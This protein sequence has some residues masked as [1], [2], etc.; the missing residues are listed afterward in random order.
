[1]SWL[2]K[3]ACLDHG[4]PLLL[5][6]LLEGDVRNPGY[7][8]NVWARSVSRRVGIAR[9]LFTFFLLF[10][11]ASQAYLTQ[12]HIHEVTQRAMTVALS[13]WAQGKEASPKDQQ[14]PGVPDEKNCPLCR[15]AAHTGALTVPL[16]VLELPVSR[17]LP[18]VVFVTLLLSESRQLSHNWQGRAPPR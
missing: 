16:I 3:K 18:P 12:T 14:A 17:V 10:A 9:A 1:M 8:P 6:V 2:F 5:V 7:K 13:G 15:L 11:F 4:E